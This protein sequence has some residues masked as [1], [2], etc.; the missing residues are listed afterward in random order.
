MYHTSAR[1]TDSVNRRVFRPLWIKTNGLRIVLHKCSVRMFLTGYYLN[2]C[3]RLSRRVL[4]YVQTEFGTVPAIGLRETRHR[5]APIAAALL[6]FSP[7]PVPVSHSIHVRVHANGDMP[8]VPGRLS[9]LPPDGNDNRP[10][11]RYRDKNYAASGGQP[12]R[13]ERARA[14]LARFCPTH[15]T[16]STPASVGFRPTQTFC[17]IPFPIAIKPPERARTFP[18][19]YTRS[20]KKRTWANIVI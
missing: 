3:T 17:P 6:D 11:V 20:P 13:D 9:I 1:S 2:P 10:S 12:T 19:T 18:S 7:L 15:S 8:R 4:R 14:Q 16:T 5:T